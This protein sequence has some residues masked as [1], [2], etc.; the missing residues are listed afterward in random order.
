MTTTATRP[1]SRKKYDPNVTIRMPAPVRDALQAL[2]KERNATVTD[3]LLDQVKP[4]ALFHSE[5]GRQAYERIRLA[6]AE[7]V[8]V[9]KSLLPRGE[10]G[11][12]AGLN[13]QVYGAE[14]AASKAGADGI[15][16]ELVTF[17]HIVR[18]REGQSRSEAVRRYADE[19]WKEWAGVPED[20]QA[21]MLEHLCDPARHVFA[22]GY[23]SFKDWK[24]FPSA[25]EASLHRAWYVEGKGKS[26][27]TSVNTLADPVAPRESSFLTTA[28]RELAR[29]WQGADKQM[30]RVRLQGDDPLPFQG[31][32]SIRLAYYPH[33]TDEENIDTWARQ[34]LMLWKVQ[35]AR[36]GDRPDTIDATEF[37]QG[38][39]MMVDVLTIE[40]S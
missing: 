18:H 13:V 22:I 11:Q 10:F 24:S 16:L 4:Y 27:N 35:D 38:K 33:I 3:V 23:V 8:T 25:Y 12:W 17:G 19:V 29:L 36:L 40:D 14:E 7:S 1:S 2:A 32:D 39:T 20:R 31:Y 15:P 34:V 9:N 6:I 28:A 37:L 21:L 5:A 30:V 26:P